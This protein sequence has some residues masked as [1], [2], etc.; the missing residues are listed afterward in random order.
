MGKGSVNCAEDNIH[1]P[2][3]LAY[4]MKKERESLQLIIFVKAWEWGE[5]T[6]R[7]KRKKKRKKCNYFKEWKI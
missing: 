7:G 2:Q 4:W 1:M 6:E 5:K 3:E